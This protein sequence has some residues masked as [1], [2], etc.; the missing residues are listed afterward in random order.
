MLHEFGASRQIP[1]RIAHRGVA[2]I[3]CKSMP[4]VVK[5]GPG[6]SGRFPQARFL[7]EGARLPDRLTEATAY[8]RVLP[9]RRMGFGRGERAHRAVL[10]TMQATDGGVMDWH[11]TR[12]AELRR[13]NGENTCF[14]I[15]IIA[16]T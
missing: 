16:T 4:K 12:L 5:A 1:V 8:S 11:Q 9:Q 15:D 10:N 14:K 6:V 13:T 3:R 7:R 2:Q